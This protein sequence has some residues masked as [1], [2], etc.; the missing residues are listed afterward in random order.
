VHLGIFGIGRLKTMALLDKE[1]LAAM[2]ANREKFRLNNVGTKLNNAELEEFT[3]LVEKRKQTPSEL[4]RE[5]IFKEIQR[6][7]EG[8]QASPE[9]VEIIGTR[10]LLV[11]IL[12][13]LLT[14]TK[15]MSAEK[16]NDLLN[17]I[18]KVKYEVAQEKAKEAGK[19]P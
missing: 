7:K 16:L 9:L 17:Q 4:I 8:V 13:P 5:L 10:L 12:Q 2:K 6:D 15:A 3:A 14:A 1:N 19:K 11:N 18:A